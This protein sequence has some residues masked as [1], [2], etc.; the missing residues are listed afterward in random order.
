MLKGCVVVFIIGAIGLI[1]VFTKVI[2]KKNDFENSDLPKIRLQID[3][4]VDLYNNN[5]FDDI[6]SMFTENYTKNMSILKNE[7]M[8]KK[9]REQ[10]GNLKISNQGSWQAR[11]YSKTNIFINISYLAKG[12]KGEFNLIF[13][14][15]FKDIWKVEGFKVQMSSN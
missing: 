3:K 14:F 9:I 2:I 6:Y 15:H 1:M 13:N 10:T 7:E 5:K 4:F 11:E 12:E 8:F